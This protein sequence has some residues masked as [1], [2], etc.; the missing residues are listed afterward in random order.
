MNKLPYLLLRLT[1][2]ISLF[3]H[4]L[5]RLPKLSAFSNWMVK[6]FEETVLPSELVLIF[7][8]ILP[9][10]EFAIGILLLLGLFTRLASIA[11]CIVMAMLIFGSCMA[12]NWEPIPSQLLHAGVLI[13]LLQFIISNSF[14]VDHYLFKSS[15]L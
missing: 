6:S 14:S 15:S 5:A 8:K 12:E 10:A 2:G 7:S 1:I 9:F 11:G 13:V 4:G 3:G